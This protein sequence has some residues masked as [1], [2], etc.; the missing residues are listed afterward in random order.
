MKAEVENTNDAAVDYRADTPQE[1]GFALTVVS[2]LAGEQPLDD[3]SAEQMAG[4]L[5]GGQKLSL[6]RE[7]DLV[8][9]IPLTGVT[10]PPGKY[11]INAKFLVAKAGFA[12]LVEVAAAVTFE[13]EGTD[14]VLP[15][16][17]VVLTIVRNEEVKAWAAAGRGD[18][19]VCASPARS[20]FYNSFF[21]T[22]KGAETF[23]VVYNAQLANQ[24]PVC[25][26]A[27]DGDA[28]RAVLYGP[29]GDEPKRLT[30]RVFLS[31]PDVISVEAG[32]PTPAP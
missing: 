20:L 3:P 5:A 4:I 12:D 17:D 22:G 1:P 31:S 10:A 26:L 25:G 28:W 18:N 19:L 27:I 9:A 14:Y 32:G 15:P 29:K 7:W 23:D 30:V 2:V 24:T 8:L 16:L 6:D 21:S 13:V 11:S